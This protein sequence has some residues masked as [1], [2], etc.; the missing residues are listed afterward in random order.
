MEET[1]GMGLDRIT[2]RI[3]LIAAYGGKCAVDSSDSPT[4]SVV[5]TSLN[6]VVVAIEGGRSTETGQSRGHLN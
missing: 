2:P 6:I 3:D 4:V 1:S 5:L